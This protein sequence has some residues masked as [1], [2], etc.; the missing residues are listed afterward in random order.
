MR[1]G[2]LSTLS[3]PVTPSRE[4]CFLKRM[5]HRC[6][7]GARDASRKQ[8]HFK[9]IKRTFLFASAAIGVAIASG[10][11]AAAPSECKLI[12][13]AEWPVRLEH[14]KLIAD[15]TINGRKIGIML[16]TGAQL[17]LILRSAAVRLGLTVRR[18]RGYRVFGLGGETDVEVAHLDEFKIGQATQKNWQVIVAGERDFGDDVAFLLG[19]DFFHKVDVEFDLAARAVRLY[20]PKDCDGVSLAYWSANAAGQV[21]IE[22]VDGNHPQIVLTVQINGQPLRALLDSGASTSMLATSDAARL[23][24]TPQ[25]PGVVARTASGLG[26]KKIDSWIGPFETFTIGDETIKNPQIRFADLWK[27]MAY[28]ETGSH[29]QKQVG[30]RPMLLGADFLLAHRVLVAHSQRKIYFTY[31]GGP[32]FQ[33]SRP[34][35][36]RSDPSEEVGTKPKTGEN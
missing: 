5:M 27:D 12:R 31:A 16:D 4:G 13:I 9:L 23:G 34:L 10:V 22:E 17:S 21:E 1:T 24:V 20:Q 18:A 19:D 35:E 3:Q 25:T 11:C 8:G 30:L 36:T 28:G 7:T 6:D 2:L 14:N 32:I 33:L 26:A 15:G 29:L